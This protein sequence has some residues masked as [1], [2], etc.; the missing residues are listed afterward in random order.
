MVMLALVWTLNFAMDPI[1]N[2]MTPK[3]KK[4][5]CSCALKIIFIDTL[6][7]PIFKAYPFAQ[8]KNAN[9][10]LH[11]APPPWKHNRIILVCH[12]EM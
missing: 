10:H 8:S 1:E 2:G 6:S 11:P 4:T 7:E 5:H 3:Y 9:M 12:S